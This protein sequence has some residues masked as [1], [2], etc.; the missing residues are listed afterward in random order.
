MRSLL[1]LLVVLLL[2]ASG[3][4]IGRWSTGT[5]ETPAAPASSSAE[6]EVWTCPM[7]PQVRVPDP[8]PCPVCG[9]DLALQ[10]PGAESDPR[11]LVMS[12]E[13]QALAQL[14]TSVVER[15]PVVRPVRLAGKVDYDE[16]QLRTIS[17][18]VGGRLERLFVDYKG[19][20]VAEGDH[21]V[22][23]YSPEL[24]TAQEELLGARER[25]RSTEGEASAFLAESNQRAYRAVREKLLLWGLTEE[26]VDEVEARGTAEDRVMLTS[27]TSGVVIEKLVD[28]GAYVTTGTP[29]YRIASLDRLWVRLDAYEQDLAW[30]RHGQEVELTVEAVPGEVFRG[31]I[32][33]IDPFV[34]E[35]TRTAKVRVNVLNES[36][37]L[38]PG[39]FVRGIALARL[40]AEGVVLGR[41]LAGKWISPMHPEVVKDGPGDCDVCGMDLVPAEELGLVD[42]SPDTEAPLVVPAS[43]LLVTGRRAVAYVEVP[44]TDE[45][46]YEGR[47]VILGPRAGDDYL[48]IE[49]LSEGERVVTRGAFRID[50]SMQ[51]LARPSMMSQQAEEPALGE[52]EAESLALALSALL[53]PYLA[54]Q[55]ALAADDPAGARVALARLEEALA[56]EPILALSGRALEVWREQEP[57]LASAHRVAHGELPVGE[58]R[59]AFQDLSDA[60]V[61]LAGLVGAPGTPGL[62]VAHCPMAFDDTGADWL[63]VGETIANPY[64]GSE[65]L[66][67]GEVLRTLSED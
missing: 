4:W 66:R 44:D 64:F 8:V 63:Q 35:A 50:S 30:L 18:W 34:D 41:H 13:S 5:T 28:Q 48:V 40:G 21:L 58:L 3:V 57:R 37:R 2:L 27:P 29:I 65:M 53:E 6:P 52:A 47:E 20:P 39:M 24:L 23:L 1:K 31:T 38:K 60:L 16:T 43:A 46:T 62:R 59:S 45:P 22:S 11:R 7:H 49:G 36:R 9:M 17:A 25:L 56:T 42:A 32:A 33:Y 54:A 67:C 26:Q 19:V 12:K 15:R 55:V 61:A 51:I 14:E 10:E